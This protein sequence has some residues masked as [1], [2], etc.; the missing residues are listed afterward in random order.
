LKAGNLA[1]LSGEGN[2]DD[3]G[4]CFKDECGNNAETAE[5]AEN[6]KENI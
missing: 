1:L 2:Q 4:E 3:F 6:R 5:G